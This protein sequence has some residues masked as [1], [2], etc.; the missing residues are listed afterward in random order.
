MTP[1]QLQRLLNKY[2][3]QW[4]DADLVRDTGRVL[5]YLELREQ[6]ASHNWAAMCAAQKAPASRT[7]R[8]FFAGRHTL[9][10]QFAGNEQ[11]LAAIVDA[12]RRQGF[13]PQANMIYDSTLARTLGDPQAFLSPSG[14]V[15]ELRRKV[16]AVGGSYDGA[17]KIKARQP[18]QPPEAA[19][20]APDLVADLIEQ[21][22]RENP[23]LARVDRRDLA[24][25]VQS[26]HGY[27]D[28]KRSGQS[29]QALVPNGQSLDS[30]I[31]RAAVT[32]QTL[33][34]RK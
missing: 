15:G 18:E 14:G 9:A 17:V 34:R 2:D 24:A 13:E 5:A 8:E 11:Q 27:S 7:D 10:Q 6:G 22:V 26:K 21:K 1:K 19:P 28:A 12:A 3:P 33:K 30:V 23:D 29:A 16:E 32:S 20:L 31:A 4:R 25:E